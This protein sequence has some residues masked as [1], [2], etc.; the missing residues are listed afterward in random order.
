MLIFY[1][2]DSFPI[3]STGIRNKYAKMYSLNKLTLNDMVIIIIMRHYATRREVTGSIP[4][5]VIAL[6]N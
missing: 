1:F 5:E 4:N 6:F 3:E 2:S